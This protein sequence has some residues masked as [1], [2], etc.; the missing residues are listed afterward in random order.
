MYVPISVFFLR[1]MTQMYI[2]AANVYACLFYTV[3]KN[4]ERFKQCGKLLKQLCHYV[5]TK[6]VE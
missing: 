3:V 4:R 2:S 5:H 6:A 1:K